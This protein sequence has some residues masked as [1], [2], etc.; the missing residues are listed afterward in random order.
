MIR[1]IAIM[2]LGCM[3][4]ASYAMPKVAFTDV[5]VDETKQIALFI[6]DPSA[7]S[8]AAAEVDKLTDGRLGQALQATEFKG[9]FGKTKTFNG[10]APF[11]HIV[12]VGTGS[13][14]LSAAKL[15]DLGGYAVAGLPTG[16][17][18]QSAIIADS[19]NTDV[20]AAHAYVAMGASLRDYHFD[21]YKKESSQTD[22]R[23][24]LVQGGD[25]DAA[26]ALF[27]S[28]LKHVVAGVYLTRDMAWEPG[29]ATVSAF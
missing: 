15:Q 8:G 22:P 16:D 6:A 18:A 29:N 24:L 14:E 23:D 10:L 26:K 25:S 3:S 11:S 2:A 12:V 17:D 9:K 28:D 4:L 19:L 13:D 21:K 1:K 7:L 27:E 5:D 20:A